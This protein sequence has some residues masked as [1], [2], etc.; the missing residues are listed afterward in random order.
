MKIQSQ[1]LEKLLENQSYPQNS[2]VSITGV[3]LG[4]DR[5]TPI[6]MLRHKWHSLTL[7]ELAFWLFPHFIFCVLLVVF[8]SV[9]PE[10]NNYLNKS[11]MDDAESQLLLVAFENTSPSYEIYC[12]ATVNIHGF[13]QKWLTRPFLFFFSEGD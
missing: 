13:I 4:K 7:R 1:V 5:Q 8:L 3:Y 10:T 12:L 2:S 6:K 11:P 9:F